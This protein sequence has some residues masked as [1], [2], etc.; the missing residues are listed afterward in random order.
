MI[1]AFSTMT[2]NHMN[3]HAAAEGH[4]LVCRGSVTK[5]SASEQPESCSIDAEPAHTDPE[6]NAGET[7]LGRLSYKLHAC[8]TIQ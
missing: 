4:L 7:I 5:H 1:L 2:H 6:H 8:G 3:L